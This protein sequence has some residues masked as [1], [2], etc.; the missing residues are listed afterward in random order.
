[1]KVRPGQPSPGQPLPFR[2]QEFD[3][4]FSNAVVEHAGSRAGQAAFVEEL[5]RVGKRYFITTPNRWFPF[6][7]HTGLPLV[8]WLPP[9]AFRKLLRATRFEYWSHE[10]HLNLLT[11][12][13]FGRL[14]PPRIQPVIRKVR[15]TAFCSNLVALGSSR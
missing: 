12:S 7:T 9:R 1:L 8:H 13:E 4:V 2:D 3:I 6:E 14:F 5:C 11:A 10:S 15:L